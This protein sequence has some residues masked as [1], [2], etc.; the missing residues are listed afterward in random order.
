MRTITMKLLAT[1]LLLS[2]VAAEPATPKSTRP[3]MYHTDAFNVYWDPALP[4]PDLAA[5]LDRI[6]GPEVVG[7]AA[8]E[9]F[10]IDEAEAK[11]ITNVVLEPRN[12][13]MKGLDGFRVAVAIPLT[14]AD[15][16]KR[17][18]F[19]AAVGK[20]LTKVLLDQHAQ[21]RN[22][23]LRPQERALKEAEERVAENRAG[24]ADHRAKLRAQTGRVEV[25]PDGLRAA[26]GNLDR[27]RERLELDAAG[28]KVR[29]KALQDAVAKVAERAAKAGNSDPAMEQ[30]MMIVKSREVEIDRLKQLVDQ[31]LA[32]DTEIANAQA[33]LAEAKFHLI[34][35]RNAAVN[36]AGGEALSA[37]NKEL[38]MLSVSVLE[39]EA[40]LERVKREL[41]RF[42]P[43]ADSIDEME[44][45]LARRGADEAALMDAK[46]SLIA[47]RQRFEAA[48]AP[49]LLQPKRLQE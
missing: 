45:L 16:E 17:G 32:S 7:A 5:L 33:K 34:E 25:S 44:T 49:Y 30:L 21:I 23:L 28:F 11:R 47:A 20:R 2:C 6:V 41:D 40:R 1:L 18:S 13:V 37:M 14:D 24:I 36:T 31:K 9:T 26:I 42:A 19:F 43:V 22:E 38:T 29:E 35:R 27:E 15:A 4:T 12:E 10:G 48:R 3:K 46:A 39:N 8:K